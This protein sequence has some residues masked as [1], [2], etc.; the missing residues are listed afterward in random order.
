MFRYVN[1]N[2]SRARR[3]D[4]AVRAVAIALDW[5]WEKAFIDLAIRALMNHDMPHADDL[6]GE[7]LWAHGFR[8]HSVPMGYTVWRFAQE[9]PNGVYVLGLGSLSHVVTVIDGDWCDIF[10]C[11]D[12]SVL[13]YWAYEEE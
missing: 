11:A 13:F 9:H 10:D 6:W 12:E 2:P 4:C 8:W 5:T 1:P 3:E 7:C